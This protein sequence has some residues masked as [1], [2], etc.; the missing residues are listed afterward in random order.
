MEKIQELKR[1]LAIAEQNYKETR[2]DAYL[3]EQHQIKEEI[4]MLESE[5]RESAPTNPDGEQPPATEPVGTEAKFQ[6]PT[7]VEEL[8]SAVTRH[9]VAVNGASIHG[10][11]DKAIA[12]EQRKLLYE[13]RAF[14]DEQNDKDAVARVESMIEKATT[15]IGDTLQPTAERSQ[16]DG[17]VN[18]S[19][20][21]KGGEQPPADTEPAPA[22]PQTNEP[23]KTPQPQKKATSGQ[24]KGGKGSKK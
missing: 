1:K 21:A 3:V 8:P 23:T 16:A 20:G 11:D 24:K 13:A 7:N 2:A 18:M 4:A 15:V 12:I 14:Y 10:M 6:P 17:T 9:I 5:A 19:E 22:A